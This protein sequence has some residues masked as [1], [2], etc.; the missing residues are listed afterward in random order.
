MTSQQILRQVAA[1]KN[2]SIERITHLEIEGA[3]W[4]SFR[5]AGVVYT[6]DFT[7]TGKVKHV[8]FYAT[9]AQTLSFHL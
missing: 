5:L 7:K 8:A 6:F 3:D 2:T 4:G 9:V 1:L